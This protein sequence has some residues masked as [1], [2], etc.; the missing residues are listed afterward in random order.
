MIRAGLLALFAIVALTLT[1]APAHAQDP[2]VVDLQIDSPDVVTVGDRVNYKILLEVDKGTGVALAAAGLPAE[3]ALVDS[4]K[5]DRVSMSD[6]REQV[7]LSF[8]VAPFVTGDV[9]LPPLEVR[10][11]NPDGSTGT[12]QTAGSAIQ[13]SSVLPAA[14]QV[15]PHGLKPQ[16]EVGTPPPT[17]PVPVIAGL[18]AVLLL[19][20]VT[21][22]V[23]RRLARYRTTRALQR[24]PVIT[25]PEDVARHALDAAGAEFSADGNLTAYYTALGNVMRRYLTERYEFPAFALTTRELEAEMMHRGLDRWQV[26]VAGGLLEQCDAVIYARYRPAAERADANLTAAYEVVEM[27]R[28]APDAADEREEVPVS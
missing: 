22:L 23:R 8:D 11:T 24:I 14:G 21:A 6:G 12:V 18:V 2:V 3:V 9:T 25:C 19:L 7:T 4:P 15:T 10:Y 26:R 28:P 27:S 17:W 16:A 13:V 1:L 20:I 5:I